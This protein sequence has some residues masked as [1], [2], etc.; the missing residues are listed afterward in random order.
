[1]V[2]CWLYTCNTYYRII[3]PYYTSRYSTHRHCRLPSFFGEFVDIYNRHLFQSSVQPFSSPPPRFHD[4]PRQV[5]HSQISTFFLLYSFLLLPTSGLSDMSIY[6]SILFWAVALS[7]SWGWRPN[8]VLTTYAPQM[9]STNLEK[10]TGNSV[11]YATMVL[12]F[13]RTG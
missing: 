9:N 11:R 4:S 1:M 10:I 13:R 8:L 5:S 12:L 7:N 2:N 3:L 6:L